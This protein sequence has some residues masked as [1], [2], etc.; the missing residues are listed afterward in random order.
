[1]NPLNSE[2]CIRDVVL[3]AFSL[4]VSYYK[5]FA[6]SASDARDIAHANLKIKEYTSGIATIDLLID[7]DGEIFLVPES[8]DLVI[9][10]LMNFIGDIDRRKNPL[11]A[12]HVG[13]LTIQCRN[14][15]CL[16]SDSVDAVSTKNI[17]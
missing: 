2:T 16:S 8:A 13:N 4:A 11:L 10:S 9:Q 7:P 12:Y 6:I 15:E 5:E 3:D 1:M 14:V 17:H